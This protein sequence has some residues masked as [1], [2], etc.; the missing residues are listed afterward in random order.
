MSEPV[1]LDGLAASLRESRRRLTLDTADQEEHRRFIDKMLAALIDLRARREAEMKL[2]SA[3]PD[4]RAAVAELVEA[5]RPIS[6][7]V[8]SR[9]PAPAP[10]M[11]DD[12]DTKYEA[13]V[14]AG[15]LRRF[16]AAVDALAGARAAGWG[17]EEGA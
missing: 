12:E 6:G 3:L 17:R 10:L 5:A 4:A 1:D 8:W 13:R 2:R 16:R 11:E 14:R 15:D 9:W 7:A